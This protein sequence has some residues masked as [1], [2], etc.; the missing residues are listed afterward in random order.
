VNDESSPLAAA[1]SEVVPLGAGEEKSV[2]ATKTYTAELAAVVLL[3]AGLARKT[4]LVRGLERIPEAMARA[5]A[6]EPRVA[7]VAA[8]LAGTEG[9]VVIARGVNFATAT[10]A[11]KLKETALLLAEPYSAADFLHGPV[12]L[13]R[14]GLLGI[15]LSPRARA[16]PWSSSP[17]RAARRSGCRSSAD[18]A[19]GLTAFRCPG[20]GALLAAR[21]DPPGPAP[22]APSRARTRLDPTRP[23]LR[24]I[25]ETR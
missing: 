19:V 24:K 25:T 15:V 3:A 14:R 13:A 11:L 18:R 1:A 10:T 2:A 4:S 16:R 12:A 8:G 21:G 23:G 17:C 9:A 6:V 22:R 20:S 7:K 5:L